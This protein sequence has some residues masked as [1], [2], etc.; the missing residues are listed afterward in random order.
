MKD[1]TLSQPRCRLRPITETPMLNPD[2]VRKY[3]RCAVCAITMIIGKF[4]VWWPSPERPMEP[5]CQGCYAWA[6]P[7]IDPTH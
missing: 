7:F 4:I 3:P 1:V 2:A 6:R 5:L